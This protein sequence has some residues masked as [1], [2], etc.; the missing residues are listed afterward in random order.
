MNR[1]TKPV[2]AID[3]I[4]GKCPVQARLCHIEPSYCTCTDCGMPDYPCKTC[5]FMMFEVCWECP[6]SHGEKAP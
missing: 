5:E 1:T 3:Y 2:I 4:G 6:V